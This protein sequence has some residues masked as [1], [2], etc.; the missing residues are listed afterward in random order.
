MEY[1]D[2]VA[3]TAVKEAI[4][5]VV[6]DGKRAHS[7]SVPPVAQRLFREKGRGRVS[8]SEAERRVKQAIE[9][10][11]ERKEIKAPNAPYNDWALIG[12]AAAPPAETRSESES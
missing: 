9:R 2:K 8:E 3:E 10:L 6:K 5:A 7:R 11:K 1:L 12:R 4:S